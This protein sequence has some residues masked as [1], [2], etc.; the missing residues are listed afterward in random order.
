MPLSLKRIIL[1]AADLQLE[2]NFNESLPKKNKRP[3]NAKKVAVIKSI[4]GNGSL[5]QRATTHPKCRKRK[6]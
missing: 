1:A 6:T 4:L 3:S 2:K 5:K